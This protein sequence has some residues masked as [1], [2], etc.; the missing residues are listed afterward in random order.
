MFG[1]GMMKKLE[2]MQQEVEAAKERLNHIKLIGEASEGKVRVEVN[3]NGQI[4][5]ITAKE[6]MDQQELLDLITVAANR[7]LEQAERTKEMEMAQSARGIM[8]G[9]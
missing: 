4:T 6:S 9:M 1:K 8:P 5:D 7:A 3:G 2:A